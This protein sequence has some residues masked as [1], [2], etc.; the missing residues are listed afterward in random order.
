MTRS[1]KLVIIAVVCALAL[2][3]GTSLAQTPTPTPTPK[4]APPQSR[5][6]KEYALLHSTDWRTSFPNLGRFEV[7]APSTGKAGEPGAYN[8]IAHSL[9][10]Y[11]RW[12]WPGTTVGEFDKLYSSHGYRRVR[13][14]DYRFDSRYEKIVLFAK[15]HPGGKIECTHGARQ[16]A[17]GTWTS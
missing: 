11:T 7:L 13:G 4:P 3:T 9:K 15:V 2:T 6:P 17:D 1:L 16:L 14:L 12:V 8:C 5:F 10:I